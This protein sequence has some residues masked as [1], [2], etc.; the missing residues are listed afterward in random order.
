MTFHNITSTS[1]LKK[2]EE[3][4]YSSLSADLLLCLFI[5]ILVNLQNAILTLVTSF[6][7]QCHV[8]QN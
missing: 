4:G 1:T 6:T 3:D 2:N 7:I 8:E 5:F